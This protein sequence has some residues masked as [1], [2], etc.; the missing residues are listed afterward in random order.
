MSYS[1]NNNDRDKTTE[2]I[3]ENLKQVCLR[4][5]EFLN[6]VLGGKKVDTTDKDN[7]YSTN[8]T[9]STYSTSTSAGKTSDF[10]LPKWLKRIFKI[11][12]IF[13]IF[14]WIVPAVLFGVLWAADVYFQANPEAGKAFEEK[15]TNVLIDVGEWAE[16]KGFTVKYAEGFNLDDEEHIS[17]EEFTEDN[18]DTNKT[19]SDEEY[20]SIFDEEPIVQIKTPVQPSSI[21]EYATMFLTGIVVV[22][23]IIAIKGRLADKQ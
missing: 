13:L 18:A 23:L 14:T 3:I 2:L 17:D 9:Y 6:F 10:K 7:M 12:V 4:M 1:Q 20:N 21:V 8:N 22:L 15:L 16:S 11:Y 19:N 5:A